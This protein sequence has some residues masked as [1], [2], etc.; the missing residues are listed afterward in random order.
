MS[1]QMGDSQHHNHE[2]HPG[3]FGDANW[4]DDV[5]ASAPDVAPQY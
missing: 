1:Q 5:K 4:L 2:S 3:S